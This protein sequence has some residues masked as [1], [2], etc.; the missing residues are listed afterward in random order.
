MAVEHSTLTGASLH[1]P[2]GVAAAAANRVYVSDGAGSGSWAQIG[3]S[4]LTTAAQP[5]SAQLLHVVDQ[6]SSSDGGTF[7]AGS[8]Q[9]RTLNTVKTNEITGASLAA[10]TI[11]LP[12]GTYW[13]EASAPALLV[14]EHQAYWYN[15]TDNSTVLIGTAEY[16]NSTGQY[17]QTRSFIRGRFTIASG[18]DFQLKH[19]CVTTRAGN[20]FG[21]GSAW[22]T[23]IY[24]DVAIWKIA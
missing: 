9:T 19:W 15:S 22:G 6:K 2:K 8:L 11:T 24:A 23:S 17:A 12:A 14:N 20:G 7:T 1:E 5:F 16:S 21:E 10:N 3:A 13:V 4:V 18:K